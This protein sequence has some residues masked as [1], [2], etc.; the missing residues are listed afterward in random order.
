M[1]Y[2]AQSTKVPA[3]SRTWHAEVT[4]RECGVVTG[5]STHTVTISRRTGVFTAEIDGQPATVHDAA[6][7]LTGSKLTVLSEVIPFPASMARALGR[8]A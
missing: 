4:Y 7:I 2:D 1:Q 6:R 3:L 5:H 8:S